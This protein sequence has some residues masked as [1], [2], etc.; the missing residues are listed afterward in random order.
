MP[1]LIID[2]A[3]SEKKPGARGFMTETEKLDAAEAVGWELVTVDNGKAYMRQPPAVRGRP[4][5]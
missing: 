3:A 5:K 4:K 2:L 1:H